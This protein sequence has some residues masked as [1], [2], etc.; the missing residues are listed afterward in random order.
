MSLKPK[1]RRQIRDLLRILYDDKAWQPHHTDQLLD[2]VLAARS[3]VVE[4]VERKT[5]SEYAAGKR[6]LLRLQKEARQALHQ[7]DDLRDAARDMHAKIL[8]TLEAIT[9][10]PLAKAIIKQ[11]D[12]SYVVDH[13]LI[14][15]GDAKLAM[16]AMDKLLKISGAYAPAKVEVEQS[17]KSAFDVFDAVEAE[18]V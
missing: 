11:D 9:D 6:E 10:L 13:S 12:G 4:E 14:E 8:A 18:E 15:A 3:D 17:V 1:H 2:V 7:V 5:A 16:A